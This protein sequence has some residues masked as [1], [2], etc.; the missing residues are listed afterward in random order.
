M[1][2]T[3]TMRGKMKQFAIILIPILITQL[4]LSAISFFD[5]NMSGRFSSVDL[6]GVAIATSLWLPVQTGLSGILI[7]I[8]PIVSQLMGRRE[9]AEVPYQVNQALWLSAA[10]A[11]IVIGAGYAIVPSILNSMRLEPEVHRV[12]I[13]YLTAISFGIIPLFAYTVLRSFIDALGQTRTSM[14]ITLIS[15]PVNVVLNAMFIYGLWFFP[16]LGGVGAG[17]AS[18]ITYWIVLM[19]TILIVHRVH[20][21]SD[22]GMFRKLSKASLSAWKGIMK[23]GV[24]I[25]FSIFFET[26]VFAAVTLLMSSFNTMTIAAH[27]AAMNFASTL[28]M[29]PLSICMSL[30]I[31]VGFEAGSGRMKDARQYA[32]LGIGLAVLL[33]LATA[34]ILLVAGRQVAGLYSS[35][36][37]VIALI[38]Q[39]L[40]FAIFFQISDAIAT[41]TQGALRGYKDVNVA[42]VLAFLSYWVIG[43]PVGYVLA[44]FT[45]LEAFG[46]WIGLITGLAVGATLM[47]LRLVKVQRKFEREAS[48]TNTSQG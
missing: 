30:T 43:L 11:L 44:N 8:T 2:Q 40:L 12:A 14:I 45:E 32:K 48:G 4:A 27:Q 6:A 22:F 17:V 5:T 13:E 23:I 31:V 7:G 33:S 9:E 25:G 16:R 19:I 35:E 28:Y 42:F 38:Q 36:P 39:F 41:P 29:L 37:E 15:L 18:A 47:L 46:Y 34:I 3:T 1:L 20:P 10:L 21:F 24:P 26:A